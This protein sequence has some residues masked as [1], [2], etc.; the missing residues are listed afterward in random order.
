MKDYNDLTLKGK[1]QRCKKAIAILQDNQN[2]SNDEIYHWLN[3]CQDLG[4]D[5]CNVGNLRNA[6]L[7]WNKYRG[8]T[9]Y[10]PLNE[11]KELL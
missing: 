11:V 8:Y 9:N 4:L 2:S 3:D 7:E 1:F 10:C 5:N 6:I